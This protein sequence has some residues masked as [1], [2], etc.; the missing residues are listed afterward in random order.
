LSWTWLSKPKEGKKGIYGF[1][2]LEGRRLILETTSREWAEK[3][4]TKINKIAKPKSTA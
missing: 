4:K 3:G 2:R 1:F